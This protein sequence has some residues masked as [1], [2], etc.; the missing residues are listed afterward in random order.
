M[1]NIYLIFVSHSWHTAPKAFRISEVMTDCVSY[2]DEVTD[3]WGP[4]IASK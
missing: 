4:K 3:G 2:D 1:I